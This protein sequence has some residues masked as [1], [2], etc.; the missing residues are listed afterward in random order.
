MNT[1]ENLEEEEI[2]LEENKT[3]YVIKYRR[4]DLSLFFPERLMVEVEPFQLKY[5]NVVQRHIR[6]LID[7]LEQ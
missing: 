7:L 6:H 5:D 1:F 3:G 2:S 4:A